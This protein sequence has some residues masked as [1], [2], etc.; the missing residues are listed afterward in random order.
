V[1]L[2]E[3]VIASGLNTQALA[4]IAQ[5]IELRDWIEFVFERMVKTVRD[6]VYMDLL[7]SSASRRD[8]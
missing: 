8:A 5:E 7:F 3:L 6:E 2:R 1:V 4:K